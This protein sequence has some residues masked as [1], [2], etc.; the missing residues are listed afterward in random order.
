MQ[1]C[2]EGCTVLIASCAVLQGGKHGAHCIQCSAAGRDAQCSLHPMQRCREWGCTVLMQHCKE[3]CTVLTASHA[4]L[5][6]EMHGA[7]C[8][9]CSAAGRDAR[10]SC[11]SAGRD[12]RCSLLH[13]S[14]YCRCRGE[15]KCDGKWPPSFWAFMEMEMGWEH[16]GSGVGAWG[17]VGSPEGGSPIVGWGGGGSRWG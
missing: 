16:R 4:A 9:P 6:G 17:G 11:S 14:C 5:Q 8:I 12:A 15:R 13:H 7:H 2:R 1:H 10:C 3:G